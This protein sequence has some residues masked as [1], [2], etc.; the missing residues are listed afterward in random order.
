MNWSVESVR[1]TTTPEPTKAPKRRSATHQAMLKKR[2]AAHAR[3]LA[4]GKGP[5]GLVD[6][7]EAKEF[8]REA[9]DLLRQEEAPTLAKGEVIPQPMAN[10]PSVRGW[11]RD[12]L[13]SGDVVAEDASVSRT[14]LLLQ[15]SF[16]VV[17]LAVDAADSI[18]AENSLEKMLAHQM[19]L[20]HE[21]SFKIV[22]KALTY[23]QRH[24]L[25]QGDSGELARLSNAAARL[26]TVFQGECLH[27]RSSERAANRR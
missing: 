14:D 15:E 26:M 1:A 13:K 27:F 16:D 20:A 18:Q 12:T 4:V 11:I 9:D 21:S 8:E 25:R 5:Y 10:E 2:Q 24:E 3:A 7:R 23:A 22:A 19:A 6:R 17:A